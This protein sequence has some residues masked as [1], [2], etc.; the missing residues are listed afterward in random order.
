M[1]SESIESFLDTRGAA[2]FLAVS[3]A[4]IHK[5]SHELPAYRLGGS[6]NGKLVF[7]P[8]ELLSWA[9]ARRIGPLKTAKAG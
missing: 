9:E 8:S 3:R 6:K 5:Y 4:F 1:T 7:K 2:A